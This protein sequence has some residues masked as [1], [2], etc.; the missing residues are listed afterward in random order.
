MANDLV[1]YSQALSD[2]ATTASSLESTDVIAIAR[3]DSARP[4]GFKSMVTRLLTLAKKIVSGID[5][6]TELTETEAKTITGAIN[7]VASQSANVDITTAIDTPASVQTFSDGG[8]NI[9]LKSLVTEIVPIQSG[10]GVPSP[11]NV[12]AISGFNSVNVVDCGKNLFDK[13]NSSNILGCYLARIGDDYKIVTGSNVFTAFVPCKPNTTYTVSKIAGSRFIIGWT[14]ELPDVN[15]TYYGYTAGSSLASLTIT[16]G[17]NAKYIVAYFY[18]GTYPDGHTYNDYLNSLQIEENN[19][20]T[21]YEAYKGSNTTIPLGS[22]IY[23]GSL[24]CVEGKGTVTKGAI[25][26]NDLQWQLR[27]SGNNNP[28]GTKFN[29]SGDFSMVKGSGIGEADIIC[30]VAVE[31]NGNYSTSDNNTIWFSNSR[32]TI[33]W[34]WGSPNQGST[35]T[36]LET[37][38]N[39]NEVW[40][41]FDLATETSLSVSGA[42]IPTL[43]GVNNIY[44]DCGDIQSLEYFNENGDDIASL[45]RLMTRT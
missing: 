22:T 4:T 29:A 38:L 37:Y 7:E 40:V 5:Y 20:A 33:G 23:G 42:N 45:V 8:D 31:G 41:V 6:S 25:K 30:N 11:S 24:E 28:N 10:S 19:Q 32:T 12:R 17:N 34:I 9:P 26:L 27:T 43:S 39:N 18:N 1:P 14:T 15:V 35:L 3:E 36:D 16:T 44:T 2:P 13:T 21:T